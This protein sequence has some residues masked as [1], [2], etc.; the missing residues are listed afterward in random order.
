MSGETDILHASTV[1]IAERGVLIIGPS[2]AGKSALALQLIALGA[3]LVADDRTRV[4]RHGDDVIADVP[5]SI[6][7]L[8]EARGLGILRVPHVGPTPLA[9]VV[10]LSQAEQDRLP[11]PRSHR[12]LGLDI[13][14]LHRVDGPHFASAIL[15]Y[16]RCSIS[17]E[18]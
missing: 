10:D 11:P 5:E 17:S 15:L 13:P 18:Q 3:T 7:G 8:I 16:L 14:C 9:L 12:V 1:R 6:A 4:S 2:G